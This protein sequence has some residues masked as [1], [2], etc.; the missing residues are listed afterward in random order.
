M[1]IPVDNVLAMVEQIRAAPWSHKK[2]AE[3][4]GTQ[5]GSL[6]R[7]VARGLTGVLHNRQMRDISS[8]PAQNH[9]L[10]EEAVREV[11]QADALK[12]HPIGEAIAV[13]TIEAWLRYVGD[14]FERELSSTPCDK[15]TG[16]IEPESSWDRC[17]EC[18]ALLCED[19]M[20]TFC[21]VTHRRHLYRR[22]HAAK[23]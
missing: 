3:L 1:S 2:Y 22:A 12:S 7:M 21:K 16:R 8:P 10:W 19:C 11:I 14:S 15:C 5:R 23:W 18:D 20:A 9:D 4:T 17:A 6:H 13:P